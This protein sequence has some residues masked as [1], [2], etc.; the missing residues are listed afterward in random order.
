MEPMRW[1]RVEARETDEPDDELVRRVRAGAFA[2]FNVLVR[3]HEGR[4]QRTVRSILRDGP[5]VDDAVQQTFMQAFV[6]L[7]RFEGASSFST[8]LT[9]IAL[10]EAMMRVRRRW[11]VVD[12]CDP[13]NAASGSPGPEREAAAR[14][15][16][17]LVRRAV[18]RLPP[19]HREVFRLRH[20]EGLSTT[21]A[22][23][24]LGITESAVKMTLHRARRL[25]RAASGVD[26]PAR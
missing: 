17:A 23:A 19:R 16:I 26:H 4:V 3:R 7:G 11:S 12:A 5:D 25:L 18:H 15:A 13:E 21:Q 6:A 10:N 22:A 20:V 9:R 24:R 14:E 2:V 1:A 8:W